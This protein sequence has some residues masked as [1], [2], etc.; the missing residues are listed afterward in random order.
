MGLQSGSMTLVSFLAIGPA[1]GE[2]ELAQGLKQDAFRPFED[3]LEEE[4]AGWCDW[5]NL[6]AADVNHAYPADGYANFGLRVDSR[7]VP[8][9]LLND[10]VGRRIQQLMRDKDL[11]FVGKEA[12]I[13]IQDEVKAELL[14]KVLPTPKH[15]EVAWNLKAG[16]V[17]ST[18]S[19]AKARGLLAGLFIK[20][21]GVELIQEGPLMLASRLVPQVPTEALLA[22]DP[23]SFEVSE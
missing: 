14:K 5:R 10:R 6:D 13:S 18:A 23:M 1:V 21:F 11:A 22:L 16:L 3:G 12:R 9:A 2:A 7:K 17:L 15:Y 20:S 4:R 8:S 19:S